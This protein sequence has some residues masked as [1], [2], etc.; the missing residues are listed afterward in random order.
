M[1]LETRGPLN[2]F[3]VL[4]LAGETGLP[5][6]RFLA[7]LGADVVKVEPP[8]GDPARDRPPFAGDLS[9]R[10]R[11]LYFLHW[12][13]NKRGITL[14]LDTPAGQALFRDL[15]R[16]ADVVVETTRPGTMEARGLSYKDLSAVNPGVV[17]T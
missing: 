9:D 14:N 1:V 2:G 16:T 11:S 5:C 8:G 13:A 10:E 12:N 3:R 6:T 4:D 15:A 7:D 17:V